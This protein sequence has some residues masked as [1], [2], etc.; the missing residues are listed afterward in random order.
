MAEDKKWITKDS[1]DRQVFDTGAQ[2]DRETGKGRYDLLP[3][4]A[5]KRVADIFERGAAKYDDRNWEK[6]MP[7]S[8]FID[9]AMRHLFQYLEGRRDEDHLGQAAWNLLACLHT[10]E[11]IER[12]ILG[13]EL[14]DLPSYKPEGGKMTDWHEPADYKDREP[15]GM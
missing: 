11:M 3:P 9:S 12:N 13:P 8:R 10:E 6:G 2:R 1:G 15:Q 14:N 7:L 5:I 4:S